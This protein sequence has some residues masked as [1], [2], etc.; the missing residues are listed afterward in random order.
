MNRNDLRKT[1]GK[2]EFI[3]SFK[4]T[5]IILNFKNIKDWEKM[6]AVAYEIA[7]FLSGYQDSQNY[8]KDYEEQIKRLLKEWGFERKN[9][10]SILK[11][12]ILISLKNKTYS[13]DNI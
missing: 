3:T 5:F 13:D 9:H 1:E 4:R 10:L 12:N 2:D 6:D 8:D 11:N 7:N